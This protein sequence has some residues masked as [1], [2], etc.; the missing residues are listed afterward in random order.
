MDN[1]SRNIVFFLPLLFLY[2]SC[3]SSA[4]DKAERSATSERARERI[5]VTV[6]TA[7]IAPL[8][9][10]VRT[11][12]A[13]AARRR[14]SVSLEQS[15]YIRQIPETEGLSVGPGELLLVLDNEKQKLEALG[16]R[17]AL[18]KA[19][20]AFG[21]EYENPDSALALL[22]KAQGR[23]AA[24]LDVRDMTQ[25]LKGGRQSEVRMA[26]SGLAEAWN[27]YRRTLLAYRRTIF[28]APFPGLLAD[29]AYKKGQWLPAATE[30][31]KLLDLSEI[32]LHCD[33][34]E[35]EAPLIAAGQSAEVTFP[36]LPQKTFRARVFA[37]NPAVDPES[38]TVRVTL[39]I[40][41]PGVL[42]RPGMYARARIAVK[43]LPKRLVVP[44]RALVLR[45]NREL[46]FVVRDSLAQ[47]CYV[48]TGA[49]N[50]RL[51][52]IV[53]SE[54]N[55]RPGEP[56]VVEGHFSLAHNARVNPRAVFRGK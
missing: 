40:A 19:L 53:S 9:R 51:V 28:K 1:M 42:I 34:L 37:V 56:V 26:Q 45:D 52:E 13:A 47:W 39:S 49:R 54:F 35:K 11:G 15:G 24:P 22:Q 17:T 36:S 18:I 32:R 20:V 44:R 6:D 30:A 41:N 23:E 5:T 43:T 38:H 4:D 55:L 33:V 3:T 14:L 27:N 16:A 2:M 7:R 8:E 21:V 10:F 12:G 25:V 46:V 50:D 31:L 48:Q 29:I